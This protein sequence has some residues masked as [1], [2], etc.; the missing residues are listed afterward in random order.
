MQKQAIQLLVNEEPLVSSGIEY[1]L[2]KSSSST[3]KAKAKG[4]VEYVDSQQIIVKESQKEARTYE[5]KQLIVS[6]KNTLSFSS[7]LVKKGEKIEKGQ[8]IA[9]GSF[10]KNNE[11][12]LGVNLRVAYFC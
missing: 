3:V 2:F 9:C 11:L 7:P 12:A 8:I 4:Q 1:S 5:L 10:A 6:N